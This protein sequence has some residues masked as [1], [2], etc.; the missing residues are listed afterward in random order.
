MVQALLVV[1][2]LLTVFIIGF[3]IYQRDKNKEPLD[4]LLILAAGGIG[5]AVITLILNYILSYIPFFHDGYENLG[6]V[7]LFIYVFIGIALVEEFS[8]WILIFGIGYDNDE[9]D[10]LFDMIVYAVFVSLG[11]ACLENILYIKSSTTGVMLLRMVLALPGHAC[12]AIFMGYY[13]GLSKLERVKGNNSTAI[14]YM[15]LSVIIPTIIHGFYDFC[16]LIDSNFFT[17]LFV[18][19]IIVLYYLAIRRVLIVSK[20]NQQIYNYGWKR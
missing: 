10:E 5:A 14:I 17:A 9:F 6:S 19:F 18:V 2:S 15:I 13:L 1:L 11:F 7:E 8:K 16:L 4:I 20:R 3:L 12:F